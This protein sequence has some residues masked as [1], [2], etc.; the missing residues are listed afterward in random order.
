MSNFDDEELSFEDFDKPKSGKPSKSDEEK[1]EV[2]KKPSSK[3]VKKKGGK[4][5][6]KVKYIIAG[7]IILAIIGYAYINFSSPSSPK[8]GSTNAK[9]ATTTTSQSNSNSGSGSASLSPDNSKNVTAPN[10]QVTKATP[11]VVNGTNASN[12]QVT[13]PPTKLTGLDGNSAPV[14]Y[15]I[16]SV[17]PGIIGTVT[18]VKKRVEMGPGVEYQYLLGN[19]KGRPCIVRVNNPQTWASLPESGSTAVTM[20]VITTKSGATIC[21]NFTAAPEAMQAAQDYVNNEMQAKQ[22]AQQTASSDAQQ[23]NN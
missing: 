7:V 4:S 1:E 10:Q 13:T 21:T 14:N 2:K 19:Y 12:V 11:G 16:Q 20:D 18:Y 17:S 9:P 15:T 6:S 5:E 3:K 8:S 22:Q 23:L